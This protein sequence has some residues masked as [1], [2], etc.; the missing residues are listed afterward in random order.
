MLA[1]SFIGKA[2]SLLFFF[3]SWWFYIPPS[4]L[5]QA[6]QAETPTSPDI[7]Q[8]GPIPTITM[9]GHTNHARDVD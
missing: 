9:N 1:L 7:T 3:L 4:G 5:N 8:G 6:L 2:A